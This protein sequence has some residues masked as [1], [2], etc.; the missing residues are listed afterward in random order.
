MIELQSLE[1]I[2]DLEG[3]EKR[4]AKLQSKRSKM[5]GVQWALVICYKRKAS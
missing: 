2:P 4:A 1:L 5:A 3:K